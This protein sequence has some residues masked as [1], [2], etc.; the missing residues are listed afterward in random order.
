M[1]AMGL[2]ANLAY[3][4]KYPTRFLPSQ[5]VH[6]PLKSGMR[7]STALAYPQP[8]RRSSR[9]GWPRFLVLQYEGPPSAAAAQHRHLAQTSHKA[10]RR[11]PSSQKSRNAIQPSKNIAA[12][13]YPISARGQFVT[14]ALAAP[15]SD[16]GSAVRSSLNTLAG[17]RTWKAC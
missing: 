7:H 1:S 8:H 10:Q 14:Q 3:K 12:S 13:A 5:W 2:K 11:P 15:P 16:S 4:R 9:R 6:R 17:C